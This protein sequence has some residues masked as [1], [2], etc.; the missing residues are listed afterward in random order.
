MLYTTDVMAVSLGYVSGSCAKICILL[1][2]INPV[3]PCAVQS[4]HLFA[5]IN[6]SVRAWTSCMLL[7]I[8]EGKW[9][10]VAV[11]RQDKQKHE[12]CCIWSWR[13]ESREQRLGCGTWGNI[14]SIRRLSANTYKENKIDY[15]QMYKRKLSEKISFCKPLTV[16]QERTAYDLILSKNS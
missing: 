14:S 7:R 12:H 6:V 9:S 8:W 3:F 1:L 16:I 10:W 11:E 2:G 13:V 5:V 4:S 15:I